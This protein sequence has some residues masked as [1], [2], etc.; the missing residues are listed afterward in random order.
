MEE[1]F[2]SYSCIFISYIQCFEVS[3]QKSG[4]FPKKLFFQNFDWSNLIFDQSKSCLKNSVSLCQVRLIKTC[5]SINWTSC[6][7]FLKTVLWLIQTL[8]QN[9]FQT[10]L[11]LFDL[12]RLH[13]RFFIVFYLIFARFF[14][15]KASKTFIPP[16]LFL[17]SCFHALFHAFKG[18]FRTFLILGF[19]LIQCYFSEIDHWVL[20]VDCYINDFCWLTWSIWGFVKIWKFWGLF[21]IWFG[22]F[23]QLDWN[24]WNWLVDLVKLIILDC[25]LTCVMINWSIFFKKTNK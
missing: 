8:L 1:H 23:V 25:F 6:F 12:A 4:Y 22:D 18:N 11:S 3:F 15:H 17:F 2:I 20:L 9:L 7:K 13:R 14:S 5:F 21:W 10:F 24:W 19:L 16:L